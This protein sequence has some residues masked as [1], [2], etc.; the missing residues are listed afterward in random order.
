VGSTIGDEENR[1]SSA[2]PSTLKVASAV[3]VYRLFV[4]LPLDCS[5][6]MVL[7]SVKHQKPAAITS[8]AQY[9]EVLNALPIFRDIVA[10]QLDEADPEGSTS[11]AS[12]DEVIAAPPTP[13]KRRFPSRR[14]YGRGSTAALDDLEEDSAALNTLDAEKF[15]GSGRYCHQVRISWWRHRAAI[16]SVEPFPLSPAKVA[17]AAALLRKGGYRS[18]TLYLAALKR[19]HVTLGFPWDDA[20][21]LELRDCTRAVL[22]GLGPPLRAAP[23]DLEAIANA[24]AEDVQLSVDLKGP[25]NA[26]DAVLVASWWML[27]E[28]EL[29]AAKLQQ[30]TLSD[31][32]GT[33]GT[34]TIDLPVSKADIQA[35]GKLRTHVCICPSPLCPVAALRRLVLSSRSAIADDGHRLPPLCRSSRTS[36]GTTSPRRTWRRRSPQSQPRAA[37]T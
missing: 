17:L 36:S 21:S 9:N 23:F 11:G 31:G 19:E 24:E 22:R 18:A 33:C 29:A 1:A 28:I 35:L 10:G 3:S 6:A 16:R 34:G 15:A 32:N 25:I 27:R 20:L 7:E 37:W 12:A 30:V 5:R 14:P 8:A 2:A 4:G 26:K 13:S